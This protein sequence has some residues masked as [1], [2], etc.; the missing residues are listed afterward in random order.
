MALFERVLLD[1]RSFRLPHDQE[2]SDRQTLMSRM[3]ANGDMEL[4][5][6]Y[7][8]LIDH[9][10]V[11]SLLGRT[12]SD[13][14][15]CLV[16]AVRSKNT[17]LVRFLLSEHEGVT[18]P[19]VPLVYDLG[20]TLTEIAKQRGCSDDM[21]SLLVEHGAPDDRPQSSESSP[22]SLSRRSSRRGKRG[23]GG[24]DSLNHSL[25]LGVDG[26]GDGLDENDHLFDD[27]DGMDAASRSTGSHSHISF[28]TPLNSPTNSYRRH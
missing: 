18:A 14:T 27:E 21:V 28:S 2:L 22:A 5:E 1:I 12:Q 17:A 16:Q 11:E 13:G 9:E 25:R 3:C 20:G 19:Q 15:N 8:S 10:T 6:L 24:D 23:G 7:M 26:E 4:V